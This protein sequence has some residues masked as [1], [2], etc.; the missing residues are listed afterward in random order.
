VGM[1]VCAR[2]AE[3]AVTS[4][5]MRLPTQAAHPGA[6]YLDDDGMPDREVWACGSKP[7]TDAKG[8]ACPHPRDS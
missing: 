3:W 7:Q 8:R 2:R 1:Q 5:V 4:H 6:V